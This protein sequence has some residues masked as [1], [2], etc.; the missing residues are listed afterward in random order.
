MSTIEKLL[1]QRQRLLENLPA[2][3]V[4]TSANYRAD[5]SRR[6]CRHRPTRD[7]RLSVLLEPL[8]RY[9]ERN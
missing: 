4:R 7:K 5:S 9:Q 6:R 2:T 1:A 3:L 8:L